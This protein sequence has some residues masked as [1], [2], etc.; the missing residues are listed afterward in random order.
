MEKWGL[1]TQDANSVTCKA[2]CELDDDMSQ[3]I[4]YLCWSDPDWLLNMLVEYTTKYK[5][6]NNETGTTDSR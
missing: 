1:F 4:E 5:E 6:V 2:S 3:K